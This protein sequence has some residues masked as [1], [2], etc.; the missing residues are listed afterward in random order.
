MTVRCLGTTVADGDRCTGG[1][2]RAFALSGTYG[3]LLRSY[4]AWRNHQ[5]TF[6]RHGGGKR[7]L[8]PDAHLVALM[9]RPLG[10]FMANP[11]TGT[12]FDKLTM[13]Y[14]CAHLE[15]NGDCGIYDRRPQLCR[16]YPNDRRCGFSGC[17]YDATRAHPARAEGGTGDGGEDINV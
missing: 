9:V 6:I 11:L 13:V 3:E 14:S 7:A 17:T 15:D 10:E 5:T 2:C 8:L 4:D 12:A 16:D 1:C